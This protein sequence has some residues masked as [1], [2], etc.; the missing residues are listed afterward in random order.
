MLHH[1]HTS[2]IIFQLLTQKAQENM[3]L[4]RQSN[5]NTLICLD[6]F[7]KLLLYSCCYNCI[8]I[9]LGTPVTGGSQSTELFNI[10]Q[11]S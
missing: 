6:I 10:D 4:I 5:K 1:F 11:G 7:A 2:M 8:C 9:S 3:T